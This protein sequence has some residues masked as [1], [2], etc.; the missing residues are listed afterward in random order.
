MVGIN[1]VARLASRTLHRSH[2][3]QGVLLNMSRIR[4]EHL[5][6][7]ASDCSVP[8][9]VLFRQEPEE[10]EDEEDEKGDDAEDENDDEDDDGYSECACPAAE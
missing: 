2:R 1:A 8:A 6:P 5:D 10:D 7:E 4:P 3:L 9:A